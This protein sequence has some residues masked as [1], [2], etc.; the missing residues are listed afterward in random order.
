[1]KERLKLVLGMITS[2]ENRAM[3]GRIM[4]LGLML[5]TLMAVVLSAAPPAGAAS[6]SGKKAFAW[7]GND[8][9]QPGNTGT[10]SNVPVAVKNLSREA[11]VSSGSLG[12]KGRPRAATRYCN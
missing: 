7:S 10:E 2:T 11:Q 3:I 12:S 6:P 8:Y 5:T 4:T 9:G 1:M